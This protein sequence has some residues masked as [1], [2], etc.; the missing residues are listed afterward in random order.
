MRSTLSVFIL[1]FLFSSGAKSQSYRFQVYSERHGLESRYINTLDQDY[2]GNL[3]IGTG[4]GLFI[5]NG[6]EFKAFHKSDGLNDELIHSS[7]QRANGDIWLGHN[8]GSVSIY[9]NGGIQSLDLSHYFSGKIA[10]M[11]EDPQHRLW[12]ISQNSG[13]IIVENDKNFRHIRKGLGDFT[14][15]SAQ[16]DKSGN[17]FLGTDLGI[18]YAQLQADEIT[19]SYP[20]EFPLTNVTDIIPFHNGVLA[21]TEDQGIFECTYEKNKFITTEIQVKEKVFDEYHIRSLQFSDGKLYCSTNRHGII[22]LSDRQDNRFQSYSVYNANG[23]NAAEN[24]NL[25]FTDREGNFWVGTIGEGLQ[26]MMQDYFSD[27]R[28]AA[29]KDGASAL[30][31]S[32]GQ[33]WSGH[34]GKIYISENHPGNFID[35]LTHRDGMPSDHVTALSVDDQDNAW[36]GTAKSGLFFYNAAKRKVSAVSLS[37]EFAN[38]GIN[39]LEILDKIVYVATDYGVFFVKDG[40]VTHQATIETGLSANVIKSLFRDSQNRIWIATT[41]SDIPFIRDNNIEYYPEIFENSQISIKCYTEDKFGNI[42]AGTDGH[43]VW[44]I[45]SAEPMQFSRTNGLSSDYCY[46][47][48]CDHKNQLWVG[49]RASISKIQLEDHHVELY[50]PDRESNRMFHENCIIQC[51][52]NN[53]FFGTSLGILQYDITRDVR[54]VHEPIL[55][56]TSISI[57][58]SIYPISENIHLRYGDYKLEF[59][60][61]GISL[62][63]PN[64]VKYQFYLEGFEN[65][66]GQPVNI[67]WARYNHLGPGK[68]TFKVKCFNGDGFGGVTVRRITI[69]ISHPFWQTW[70]FY[71]LLFFLAILAFRIIITRRERIL[72]ANQEKLQRALDERTK[73][74]VLQKTL[75]EEKNKDITDS[76]LYAKNIQN[77]MLPPKGALNRYFR[78]SYVYYKPR[79]IVSGDFYFVEKFSQKIIV[80]VA[81]CTGHGVPGAFMSLIGSTLIKDVARMRDVNTPLELLTVLDTELNDILNKKMENA[82]IPDGMDISIIDFDIDTY[83][84]RFASANRPLFIY[85]KDEL[86]E[87]KGDR[88]SIGDVIDRSNSAFTMQLFE[89]EPGDIVYM[90]SDGITDQFGGEREKK[91]KRAGLTR[92]LKSVV[93]LPLGE[94]RESLKQFIRDWKGANEQLDDMLMIAFQV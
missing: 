1:F 17:L 62:Q 18:V 85:T 61:R 78:D 43:G 24:I 7:C 92:H 30:A 19:V 47:I 87:V 14:I 46:S 9:R 35:S 90:F 60:F 50:Q 27:Y 93:H 65:D 70:W 79:D 5:F 67:N 13:I 4:E 11:C 12:V 75:L 77:A 80:A 32:R 25:T 10:D 49:H 3:V 23:N 64:G 55:N 83:Q 82:G 76:I 68:Y 22:E 48:L 94:Q 28:M 66:W 81:D 52:G 58:D 91:L 63:D 16:F 69:T 84:L 20:D 21:A 74:V 51:F 31:H 88:R 41:T 89:L 39:D 8:N 42:W 71:F 86:V 56:F 73:E 45:T 53:I 38:L 6:T 2:Q 54:N 72:R 40:K 34:F 26:Q 15:F 59:L 36:I 29:D 44:C 57:S 37:R 33:L